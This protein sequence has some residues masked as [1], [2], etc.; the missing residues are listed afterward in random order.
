MLHRAKRMSRKGAFV[1]KIKTTRF[2]ELQV[3]NN[4]I[5]TFQDGILGF[6]QL[7]KFFVIDPGDSTLILWLQSAEDGSVAFPIIEPKI[8]KPDYIV[9]LMPSELN[10]L[11]LEGVN[12]AKIYSI[13]TIPQDVVEMSAN[14]KAPVVINNQKKIAKQI[15]LQDS[16]LTVRQPIYKELKKYIV[17]FASND[18]KRTRATTTTTTQEQANT[19]TTQAP[20]TTGPELEA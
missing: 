8:F 14:L 17:T 2:G 18:S 7:K 1:I 4:D 19:N 6:E 13:L 10:S 15:V 11:E 5:I 12:N 9:K 3:E 16:K 20:K